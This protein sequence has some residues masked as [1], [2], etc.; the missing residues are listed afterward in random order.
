MLQLNKTSLMNPLP[1]SD[2]KL[3]HTLSVPQNDFTSKRSMADV[4]KEKL[5]LHTVSFIN[6]ILY[7]MVWF[8]A[9]PSNWQIS[10]IDS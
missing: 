4:R 8:L 2:K 1:P 6:I 9:E 7:N 3:M 5:N 10:L